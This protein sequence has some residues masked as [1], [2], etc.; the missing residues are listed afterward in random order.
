LP[1]IDYAEAKTAYFKALRAEV[2]ELMKIATGNEAR[3]EF[4]RAQAVQ[5]RFHKDFD[6]V[7]FTKR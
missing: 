6:G 4:E 3:A 2:P 1:T 7:D 5:K